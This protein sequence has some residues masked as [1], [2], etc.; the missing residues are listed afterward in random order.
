MSR[1]QDWYKGESDKEYLKF[2]L[3]E[4]HIGDEHIYH[5]FDYIRQAIMCA[6][7]TAL[8]KARTMDG[9]RVVRGVDGWGVEHQCRDWD[10]IFQWAQE[11][12]SG[13]LEGIDLDT[14]GL[15]IMED[16]FG[17]AVLIRSKVYEPIS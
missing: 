13:D 7:D 5:C 14:T 10:A 11:H 15:D 3:G 2:A 6:G 16:I 12:R 4:E 9:G 1:L 17:T 8:E